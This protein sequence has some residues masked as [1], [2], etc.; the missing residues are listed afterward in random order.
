MYPPLTNS[1][2]SCWST[3]SGKVQLAKR[4]ARGPCGFV[5]RSDPR[6]NIQ[7]III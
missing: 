3:Q 7:H 6:E 1:T 2:K 4:H 5:D